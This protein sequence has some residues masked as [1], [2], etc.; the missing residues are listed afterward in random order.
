ME[1]TQATHDAITEV[2]REH[3]ATANVDTDTLASLILAAIP[4]TTPVDD[5][6]DDADDGSWS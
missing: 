5:H 6:D 4:D 2:L 1:H 3:G